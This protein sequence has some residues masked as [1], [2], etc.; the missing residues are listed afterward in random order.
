MK[1]M[2]FPIRL[3]S[4]LLV[5]ALL[6]GLSA[7][8]GATGANEAE[9]SFVQVDNSAVSANLL[10]QQAETHAESSHA[11]TDM[12]RVSIVLEKKSVLEAGFPAEQIGSNRA[13]MAYRAN[14][15]QEQSRVQ[16]RIER[17]TGE[18]LD[19]VW[20]LTLTANLI[21]ANVAYGQIPALEALPGVEQVFLETQYEPAVVNTDL[22]ADPNM[23]TSP[24]MIGSNAAWAAGYTGAGS[25]IAIIDTGT[26]TDHQSFD[27]GAFR[28]SLSQQAKE[29]GMTEEAYLE[30]LDL[31]DKEEIASVLDQLHVSATA[32][33]LYRSTKL[34]FAFNYVDKSL[35]VTHD[36]D[37]QTEHGSHVAGIAAANAYIP[38]GDGTYAK[39]LD[40]VLVQGV[41]PDAQIITMKVFGQRGG[42]FD[43]DYMVAI[44]D[45]VLLGCDAVNLS[46]GGGNP[47]TSHYSNGV[48]RRI[49]ENLEQSG[50]VAAM[51]AGNAGA[52]PEN[53]GSGGYLYDDGVS[54]QTNSM[55]GTY[56]NSLAVA[57]VDNCGIT[58]EYFTVGGSTV[59]YSQNTSDGNLPLTT[60][61]GEQNYVF[62]DGYGTEADWA[63]V[64]E[65]LDGAIAVCSRGGGIPF[66]QKANAAVEAGAIATI[67]YNNE[68][69]SLNMGLTNYRY[70]A[71]CVSVTRA[72]GAMLK[73]AGTSVTD[74]QGNIRYYKGKLTVE[75]GASSQI[76][77]GT[78]HTMSKFS[79]WGVPGSLELKPEVTAPG[80]NIYSVNGSHKDEMGGPLLGGSDAYES[81]S[82]T[83]MASPQ[84]AG[85][86]A[87]VSQYIREKGLEEQTGLTS[88]Q[89]AQS[90][91][92]ST[93]V[94]QR[95]EE[96]DGAYYPVLRQGAGLANVGAAI[97]AESYILM[98]RDATHSYADGKVKV[99]LGDDPE[100]T[101]S[102]QFSFDI[103]NMTDRELQ[104]ALSADFFTQAI[105]E[106]NGVG[107]MDTQTTGLD[108]T[109]SFST[110]NKVTV[111][112]HATAHVQVTVALT[113]AQKAEL[114][115]RYPVGAYLEGFVFITGEPTEEGVSGTEHSIPVLGFYGNWTDASMFDIGSQSEYITGDE[116]RY[117]YL[118]ANNGISGNSF[119]VSYAR[120]PGTQYY[121]GG[122]PVV[123]DTHYMP[124]R[125]AINGVNGDQISYINFAPIRNAAASRYQVKNLSKDG[126][127]LTESFYGSVPAAYYYSNYQQWMNTGLNVRAGFQPRG[128]QEGDQVELS[129]TLAPE[130]NVSYS[131]DGSAT[132]DWEALG[133]G[134]SFRIAA[135]V[136]NTAPEVTDILVSLI[137]DTMLVTARDNQYVAAVSL[138]HSSGTKL[139]QRVGAQQEIQAGEE[140]QYALDLTGIQGNKF[141]L[142]VTDYAMN[143]ATFKVEVQ[144]GEQD[145]LP[146]M[147]AFDLDRGFW[148][149]FNRDAQSSDLT[150]YAP[151]DLT[152]YAAT[153]V[154]HYVLASTEE[155]DLYVMPED[156]LTSLTR[157]ANLGIVL[158][159]MAYN[160][161]DGKVYGVADGNLVTVDMFTAEVQEVGQIPVTTNMLACDQDGVF[162][163]NEYGTGKIWRFTL[164]S[165][166]PEQS[167]QYDFNG[168]GRVNSDDVQ[169][170]LDY[171]TGARTE[172]DHQEYADLD[173]NGEINTRDA[174][175]FETQLEAG[176]L[177]GAE[178]VVQTT[179]STTQYLQTMEINP[180]NGLL[181]WI[182]YA[183]MSYGGSVYSFAYYFEIDP[184]SGTYTIYH[185]LGHEMS[186]LIIPERT[187]GSDWTIPTEEVRG[188]QVSP[189]EATLLRGSSMTLTADVL[190]WTL[191]DRSV[192]WSSANPEVATV[193]EDGVVTGVAAGTTVITATSVRNPD[194]SA[195]CTVTV[196]A[197]EVT[198]KG[199]LRDQEGDYTL[200]HWDL[201]QPTWSREKDL[202]TSLISMTWDRKND[203]LYMMDDVSGK[204]N[205]HCVNP[206]TGKTEA[207]A[208]NA[209][210]APFWD[211]EYSQY[212]STEDAPKITGVYNSYFLAP[213]DP[214]NLDT[215][216]FNLRT[217]LDIAGTGAL[218]A[219]T[220]LGYE[221]IERY[222]EEY[223]AEH[224]VLL[225]DGGYIWNWWVYEDDGSYRSFMRLYASNLSQYED[226]A[227][228]GGYR[229]CS[230][231]AGEDGNLYLS[232]YN[233]ETSTFYQMVGKPDASPYPCY[234]ATPIGNI[235][236]ATG[237]VALYAVESR[238]Q[239]ESSHP[240]R[241][242][243]DAEPVEV[244]EIQTGTLAE[245]TPSA[246]FTMAR[247]APSMDQAAPMSDAVVEDG[248]Q[249]IT[250]VVTP[251]D[252][253]G[254]DLASNNGL[255]VVTYHA[256]ALELKDIQISGDYTASV[257]AAGAVTLGYLSGNAIAAEAPAA[258]LTFAVKEGGRQNTYVTVTHKEVNAEKPGYVEQLAVEFA[259]AN[260]E[261]RNAKEAT[262]TEEGYTGDTYCTDCGMLLTK[263]EIIPAKG[264]SF[265]G[266]T[267]GQEAT[268]TEA[269]HEIRICSA[270]GAQ[271]SRIVEALGH[272]FGAWTVTREP[273]C[274]E[275]GEESCACTRCQETEIRE[276]P[277]KGHTCQDTVVPST[278][279]AEGYT[280]H[281]CTVCDV[282]YRDT[283]TPAL[284]HSFGEWTVEKEADCFHDGLETHVCSVCKEVETR[285][286]PAGS[287]P[288]PSRN[289][290]DVDHSRW[291]HEGVD[292][293]VQRGI[294][295]G[296]ADD[297]FQPMGTLTRGQLVTTLYRMAG[298][299]ATEGECPFRDVDM[300][301][302]YGKAVTWAAQNGIAQGVSA[303]D[304]A[305]NAPVTREQMVTFLY[306][307]AQLTGKDV[308]GTYDLEE[309][310]DQNAIH[311]YARAPMAWSVDQGLIV[312]MEGLLNPRGSA[313][314]AQ[315][316][317]IFLRY[318]ENV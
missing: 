126:E 7:P 32:E 185:N 202:D 297:L 46:L 284:G 42:A 18:K 84:V 85:M 218:V 98:G 61:A 250:V 148:T 168:D 233:G 16:E 273:T 124:E 107:Y 213:M 160:P 236:S 116:R 122:N 123:T 128:V 9:I 157:V 161:A 306:R 279:E 232:A 277:A 21:S 34:P 265:G 257:G 228:H 296:V 293:V 304:F 170:L 192:T 256:A 117:P 27:E 169:A 31:L 183:T 184:A 196:E 62:I 194:F 289:F 206:S 8:I 49:M 165:L 96:N 63:A 167:V 72:D 199:A 60:I 52:W 113:D 47:G 70:S 275:A 2:Q 138:Y 245:A 118:Y 67:V 153:I 56:T 303:W 204:W 73:A 156:D 17:V 188:V 151:S 242:L 92:M 221:R 182:S 91:L 302:F 272:S 225:D 280:L 154:D 28:Y 282:T 223:D 269:G 190:P 249:E 247:V 140:A 121:F 176:A 163:C 110:G 164:D 316:A 230:L 119:L 197:I 43:S 77:P 212:F 23:S 175:L 235:G 300:D 244:T 147:I 177:S 109:V 48:Y 136:D 201:T 274:T 292:F 207:S 290:R 83:S 131:A 115:S 227:S 263:G 283:F 100:K 13:A 318:C 102:Y 251:K 298:E 57:S 59:V 219:V 50:I 64:G 78:Y 36:N 29:A 181:C 112:A 1:K 10:E 276:I 222:G 174:Y 203:K 172:I 270:C 281:T 143:T 287:N 145:E 55:P 309:F 159:D 11:S 152:F 44:E 97:A 74:S 129:L 41:A 258:T 106:E 208:A 68:A 142:Q 285:I 216:S 111:P 189:E 254:V 22:P 286:V 93:A 195:S 307:Y 53:A 266:W 252:A 234:E 95:E 217:Y 186:C 139:L 3:V 271:E 105:L 253:Q 89:L 88:R 12:V 255:I 6:W 278:C 267:V 146:E 20:N 69:G 15:A 162:Y 215:V 226:F 133:D 314:R 114:Q 65:D 248:E 104:Y 178:L 25:R 33:E 130:Y 19:V 14:L 211:L 288:C 240:V 134:A 231:V 135:V 39:A 5:L 317:V 35:D 150:S 193:D 82:G 308:T 180:N 200:F 40:Q 155:G 120:E 220:S 137:N 311:D 37:T 299:P 239:A 101:G 87:L 224:F 81:M 99:E 246:Y 158:T 294:M 38:N 45:A 259:H 238:K 58:G 127:V 24:S 179:L 66:Y 171:A 264:H 310:E 26:D 141:L 313:T 94:P 132:V 90:L 268:C 108:A 166:H 205:M 261:L 209:A 187:S 191:T 312:G 291:Y 125:N 237:P 4:L 71:P 243:T 144:T 295:N 260:T 173:G 214:M 76:Q 86:A 103:H 30:Q 149:S 51:S 54:M 315:I 229:Y 75:Q 301:R 305:P 241:D 80:G 198:L 79:S 210:E 262:C